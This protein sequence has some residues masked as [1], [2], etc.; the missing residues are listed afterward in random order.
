MWQIQWMVGLIPT[1]LLI[2]LYVAMIIIGVILYFGSKLCRR[3]PFRLIPFLGQYPILSEI[4]GVVLMILGIYLWG[5]YD[6]EMNW[7][8]RVA[9]LEAKIAVSEQKSKDFN[10]KL[11]GVI[12]EKNAA[13][14]EKDRAIK[15]RITVVKNQID[16]ECTVDS[17][18]I[19]ILNDSA[20]RPKVKK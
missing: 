15:N 18:A 12:K 20:K 19:E 1:W 16:R 13:I 2:K 10:K 8:A 5:G 14:K 17:V 11:D 6:N 9:E 7:R 3:W 4:S